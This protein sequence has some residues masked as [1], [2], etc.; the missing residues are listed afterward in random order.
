M[1]S[2]RVVSTSPDAP[3]YRLVKFED[4]MCS[5]PRGLWGTSPS[6]HFILLPVSV[7]QVTHDH[8]SFYVAFQARGIGRLSDSTPFSGTTATGRKR[9]KKSGESGNRVDPRDGERA[10]EGRYRVLYC[11]HKDFP[12]Q[13][14]KEVE[15]A[16]DALQ[17]IHEEYL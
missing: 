15:E 14:G 8:S 16:V 3:G 4:R 6:E 5:C 11:P 10:H 9:E 2:L 1:N 7:H 12:N 13:S 17:A